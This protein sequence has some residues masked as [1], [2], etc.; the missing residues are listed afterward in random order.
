MELLVLEEAHSLQRISSTIITCSRFRV[1]S[2][3][4]PHEVCVQSIGWFSLEEMKPGGIPCVDSR[5][6]DPSVSLLEWEMDLKK[7]CGTL[8]NGT[9]PKLNLRMFDDLLLPII[10]L[11]YQIY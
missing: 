6:F 9:R 2:R 10:L 4:M 11:I 5:S 1:L 7:I 3:Y 8:F